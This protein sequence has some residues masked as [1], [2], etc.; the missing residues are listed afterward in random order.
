[1]RIAIASGK[2]GTGKTTVAVNMA[3]AAALAGREVVYVDCDVEEPNGHLFLKP[4]IDETME[5][6][7]PYPIIDEE[8]CVGC[9]KC[10]EIC[11]YKAIIVLSGKPLVFQ[12]M[13]HACGGCVHVCPVGAV[14][15]AKRPVGVIEKGSG[16]G[17]GFIHGVLSIGQI[18]SPFLI[19][20][21]KKLM[22]ADGLTL[23]DCPPGTSCPVVAAVDGADFALLITEPTPFGLNDLRLAVDMVK[24]LD[25]SCGVFINRADSETRE[26][27]RYCRSVST[28][29][30]GSLPDDRRIAERYS[31][32]DIL[33]DVLPEFGYCFEQALAAVEK[34]EK[35][36]HRQ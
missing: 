27:E 19:R 22:P 31:K 35:K 5:A 20:S 7:L 30:V 3:R 4:A 28:P 26:I 34:G 6:S 16:N 33:V 17:V 18:A 21:V 32:G 9:G 12:D 11:R 23:I 10:A 36:G 1:M 13:C 24:T 2:G 15:E 29:V 25:I 8:Q 14:T